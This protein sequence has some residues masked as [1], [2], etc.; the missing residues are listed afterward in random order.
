MYKRQLQ[1]VEKM[2]ARD[3][4]RFFV[5]NKLDRLA[6]VPNAEELTRWSGGHPWAILS[7][8]DAE[9]I[10][11]LEAALLRNART[12]DEHGTVLVPYDA[13]DVL[14]LVYGK[15][16]VMSSLATS[17]GLTLEIQGPLSVMARIQ[18]RLKEMSV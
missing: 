9:A 11:D 15:C 8:H 7:A 18:R 1:I 17:D 4:P 12:E 2:G 6:T 3:V 5:F 14:A 16:R 13:A 10:A